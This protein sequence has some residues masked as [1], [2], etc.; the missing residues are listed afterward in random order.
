MT[1]LLLEESKLLSVNKPVLIS[2]DTVSR[3]NLEG[4]ST[5]YE[6][7]QTVNRGHKAREGLSPNET[8]IV[9][10]SGENTSDWKEKGWRTCDFNP[11]FNSDLNVDANDL[12]NYVP[13]KSQ[14]FILAEC[15]TFDKLSQKGVSPS[16]LLNQA[17]KLLKTGG[18]L[19]VET[20][21]F[22]GLDDAGVPK[23]NKYLDLMARHGFNAV[24]EVFQYD[25]IGDGIL[26]QKIIY[27]GKKVV[28]GH[29]KTPKN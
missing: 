3:L 9:V 18:I 26:D 4:S 29:I 23:R 17:N 5:N 10:G 25:E 6:P 16:R 11:K 19:I 22:E 24:A 12:E 2:D 13:E 8:G 21:N 28:D 20:A 15:V 27:Y 1:D 14:D 7:L